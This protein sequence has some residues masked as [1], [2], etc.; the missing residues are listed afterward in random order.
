MASYTVPT[1]SFVP[2]I[3]A[4]GESYSAEGRVR[5]VHGSSSEVHAIVRGTEDYEVRLAVEGANVVAR[6]A[7]PYGQSDFCKHMWAVICASDREGHLAAATQHGA[8]VA[9]TLGDDAGQELAADDDEVLLAVAG[10]ANDNRVSP[11][12]EGD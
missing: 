12:D 2:A 1:I 4:R 5:L 3:R 10:P 11:L 8:R 9:L 7:C 6:C